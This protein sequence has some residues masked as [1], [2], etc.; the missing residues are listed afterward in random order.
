MKKITALVLAFI[1][2]FSVFAIMGSAD[3]QPVVAYVAQYDETEGD[4]D[5]VVNWYEIN[6]KYY[7]FIPSSIDYDTAKFYLTGANA[8]VDGAAYTEA[9][10]L[11]EALRPLPCL[12]T[13][14]PV[15]LI[16][17]TL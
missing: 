15:I 3:G 5:R 4:V 13:Q 7:F 6:G 1:M 10:T 8:T 12:S 14:N 11:T 9:K 2:A 17:S 16:I